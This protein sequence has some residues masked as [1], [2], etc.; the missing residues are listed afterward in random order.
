MNTDL[1]GVKQWY[2]RLVESPIDGQE[3]GESGEKEK[4]RENGKG[5]KCD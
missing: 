3:D 2:K 5:E 1:K 4:K